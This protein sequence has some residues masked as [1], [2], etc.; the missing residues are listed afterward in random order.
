MEQ[1][2]WKQTRQSLAAMISNVDP[3][4]FL[5]TYYRQRNFTFDVFFRNI[6][7]LKMSIFVN[8]DLDLHFN[9]HLIDILDDHTECDHGHLIDI[10][11]EHI[12]CDHG[13]LIDILDG[14]T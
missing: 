6:R 12:E 3:L 14:H 7:V 9:G 10:L 13:H 2:V 1:N 4:D 5:I 8:C 11:D